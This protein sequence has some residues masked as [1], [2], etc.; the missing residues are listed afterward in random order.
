MDRIRFWTDGLAELSKEIR[1]YCGKL[2][3]VEGTIR[4][5]ASDFGWR[6]QSEAGIIEELSA[7]RKRLDANAS[8][9]LEMIDAVELAA[10]ETDSVSRKL[11]QGI[12]KAAEKSKTFFTLFTENIKESWSDFK[13]F[14]SALLSFEV[15]GT[16]LGKRAAVSWENLEG[17]VPSLGSDG[18]PASGATSPLPENAQEALD[19]YKKE[20]EQKKEEER[21]KLEEEKKRKTEAAKKE[22]QRLEKMAGKKTGTE[23]HKSITGGAIPCGRDC[24]DYVDTRK[25][26]VLGIKMLGLPGCN[27]GDYIDAFQKAYPKGTTYNVVKNGEK[28][29]YQ[30]KAY[31]DTTHLEAGSIVSFKDG[32]Y[33][34]V[35][36]I[37][38]VERNAK[39]EL[40]NIYMSHG[41]A[42]IY[43]SENAGKV[44]K[45]AASDFFSGKITGA[46]NGMWRGDTGKAYKYDGS[47]TF[48]RT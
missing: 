1:Y 2:Q 3:Y 39:G 12:N 4:S 15:F 11:T 21:R 37:E 48:T 20:L 16:I 45:V 6:V 46:N 25:Y 35:V 32:G 22:H 30:A 40:A 5:A 23:E 42:N 10:A 41:G 34:H 47:I 18:K 7:L 33:G 19:D 9:L 38:G 8:I 36:F 27:G 28:I 29:T 26:E 14:A 17:I 43:A 13:V 24:D 44:Y 31:R